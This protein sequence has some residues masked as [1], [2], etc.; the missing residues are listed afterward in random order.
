MQCSYFFCSLPVCATFWPSWSPGQHEAAICSLSPYSLAVIAWQREASGFKTGQ[1]QK[2]IDGTF[3]HSS[4]SNL[5]RGA[6]DFSVW[7]ERRRKSFLKRSRLAIWSR[8]MKVYQYTFE[9]PVKAYQCKFL[10]VNL[11]NMLCSNVRNARAE[12]FEALRWK[13]WQTLLSTYL[14]KSHS[15]RPHPT[16]FAFPTSPAWWTVDPPILSSGFYKSN[17][18]L[19]NLQVSA[20]WCNPAYFGAVSVFA[21]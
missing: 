10:G 1:R 9:L 15:E 16:L 8:I 2:G 13:Y 20:A 3:Y 5:N 4:T 18:C 14:V 21:K 19:S 11:S 17:I 6:E 7:L 12:S